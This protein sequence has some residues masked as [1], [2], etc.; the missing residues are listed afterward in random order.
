M[1]LES[2]KWIEI[3]KSISVNPFVKIKCPTCGEGF[4][5]II[6]VPWEGN[7]S[8]V[9][10]HLTCGKCNSKNVITKNAEA[11]LSSDPPSIQ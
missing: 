8:K 10:V 6:I 11:V 3:A 5:N 2:I 4:L 7:E 1:K 9:D